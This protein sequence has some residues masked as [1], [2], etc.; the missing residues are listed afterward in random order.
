MGFSKL[1]ENL[2]KNTCK[3][4]LNEHVTGNSC[5]KLHIQVTKLKQFCL[6][7][8]CNKLLEQ[9]TGKRKWLQRFARY[10]KLQEQGISFLQ[11]RCISYKKS[12]CIASCRNKLKI[13]DKT[14]YTK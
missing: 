10:K 7:D 9:V 12:Y 4:K 6:Q 2:S 3:G 11:V 5:N 14:S 8:T 1:W 13:I